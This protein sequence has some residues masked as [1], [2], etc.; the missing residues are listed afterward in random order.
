MLKT[1]WNDG[2]LTQFRWREKSSLSR[3]LFSPPHFLFIWRLISFPRI[4]LSLSLNSNGI[5]KRKCQRTRLG[6]STSTSPS[7]PMIASSFTWKKS[8][9]LFRAWVHK[10][11]VISC[12]PRAIVT[13]LWEKYQNL[14]TNEICF[15]I[16]SISSLHSSFDLFRFWNRVTIVSFSKLFCWMSEIGFDVPYI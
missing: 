6:E 9:S 11:S 7:R 4:F 14:I 15:I 8:S 2:G 3:V 1:N 5:R 13:M 12:S 16:F 10:T